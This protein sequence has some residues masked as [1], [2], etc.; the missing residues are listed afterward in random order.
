MGRVALS[1]AAVGAFAVVIAPS[2]ATA[3]AAKDP[4]E[5]MAVHRAAELGPAPD[6]A[7]TTPDGAPARVGD[8]RGKVVLLGFFTTW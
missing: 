7:F 4:F 3:G 8:F 1:L 6:V 5:A 2:F